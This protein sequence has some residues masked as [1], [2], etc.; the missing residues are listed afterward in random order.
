[1]NIIHQNS[2]ANP[3]EPGFS[4]VPFKPVPDI[5]T[6]STSDGDMIQLKYAHGK[7]SNASH[8]MTPIR[9]M[10]ELPEIPD[11]GTHTVTATGSVDD[12]VTLTVDSITDSSS[13]GATHPFSLAIE[14]LVP[15]MHR[16]AVIH[17]NI[18][19]YP[20]PTGNISQISGQVGPCPPI[21]IVPDENVKE[22][23]GCDCGCDRDDGDAGGISIPLPARSAHTIKSGDYGS[24]SA[25]SGITREARLQYMRWSAAFGVFRGMGGIPKGRLELMGYRYSPS[26][27][28]PAG[29]AY[30]HP[31]SSFVSMPAGG[32]AP[33]RLFR[34]RE[35][36][37]YTNYVCDA[38]GQA[39]F[40]VGSTSSS[41]N[42]AAFVTELSRAANAEAPLAEANYLRIAKVDGS[43]TF[44]DLSTGAFAGY[45]SPQDSLLTAQS[46][47]D[48]LDIVRQE[49]GTLRQI[50][51]LWDGLADITTTAEGCTIA[52]YLPGQV[53][54][55]DPANG[56]YTVEGAP[57][58][59]FTISG[60]TNACTLTVTEK[61]HTLPDS[62]P[63]YTTTWTEAD[64]LWSMTRGTGDSAVT[65]SRT[66]AASIITGTYRI[67]TTV[68]K[69]GIPAS[70]T[71]ADYLS[72]PTGELLLSRTEGYGST[73][74]QTT[75]YA[76]DQ[77]GSV[78][79]STGPQHGETRTIHDEYGRAAIV[80]M[81]WAGGQNR[82]VNTSYRKDGS[83]WSNEPSRVD[84]SVVD[85]GGIPR[86]HLREQYS[87][88]V[89]DHIKRIE[90]RSEANG[91]T[92]L[93]ITETW[94]GDAANIHARGRLHMSQSADGIQTW[95]DYAPTA[96]YGALYAITEETR[97]DGQS[98]TG[99]STRSIRYITAQGNTTREERYILDSAGAWQLL[100]AAD[101]E[102]DVQNR[103]TRRTQS[104]GRT[105]VR[106]HI[107]T[108]DLLS[109]TDENGVTTSHAYDSARQ[110]IETIRS[111]T[112]VTP[113]TV[114]TWT[115]DAHGRMLQTRRDTGPMT[116]VETTA[117]DLLGR[118]ISSTDVLGR[119]TTYAY[120][121][122][123]LT[124]TVTTPSGATFAITYN[125][126][127]SIA[128]EY[129]TGQRER[130]HTWDYN[131]ARIRET[132][133][134][135]DKTTI[136][137][138]TLT[139][140]FGQLVVQTSPTTT[141]FIYDRTTYNNKGQATQKQRDTGSGTESI[142]MAPTLY[143]Y[144][145]FG[146]LTKETWKLAATPTLANSRI[147]TWAYRVEQRDDG[148]YRITTAT[149]NNGKGTTFTESAAQLISE[150][151]ALENRSEQTDAR[152]NITA[153]WTEYGEGTTR[154]QK[155][156]LPTSTITASTTVIDGFATSQTDT[157]DVTLTAERIWT[158]TGMRLTQT[159]GRGNAT[160]TLTDMAGRTLS[161]TDA[162]GN[163][164]TTAYCPCCD[165]PAVITDALG[166]TACYAYDI[167]GR[168]TAEWGTAIQ[169]AAFT[170]DE[171]DR[172]TGLTTWRAG[173]S[174]ITSDPSERTDGDTTTW[175]YHDASG[176]V[177]RKTYANGGH[178][179]TVYTP[180]GLA[181]S[182][183]DA[184]GM[185]ASYTWDT[186]KGLCTKIEY[187]DS[188]P[189]KQYTHNHIGNLYRIADAQGTRDI[190]YNIYN[191]KDTDSVTVNGS[192]HTVTEAYDAF[193]R[194]SGYVLSK[195]GSALDTVTHGYGSYGRLALASFLHGGEKKTFT[196]AYLPGT[197]LPHTLAHP[198][199]IL[200][201]HAYE[202][203][204]DLV[205][206]MN[207]TR[208]AT[209]VVLRGYTYDEPGRPITRSCSRQGNTRN[210]TF[211]YNTRSELTG[212]NLGADDYGYAYDNIGNRKT[213]QELAEETTYDANNLNQYTAISQGIEVPF[214]PEYDE[215]G[216]QT[217]LQTATGIWAVAYNADNRPVSFTGA[218]G[219]TIVEC[220]YDY[221]GRRYMKK[222]TVNGTVTLHQFYLYR[223]YLQIAALDLTRSN[224]PALWY[225]HWDPTQPVATRPLSI[226]KNGTWFTYGHDLT[227]NVTELY[228]TD[229]TIAT[230]YDYTPYGTVTATGI[231]QPIQWSSEYNDTELGLT[232]YNYRHY[233][234]ADGRWI[235]RELIGELENKGLYNSVNNNT[236]FFIDHLGL[237]KSIPSDTSPF[238]R[239]NY[240]RDFVATP[241]EIFEPFENL[242]AYMLAGCS[243]KCC[244]N[245]LE[246]RKL[247]RQQATI[248]ANNI[249]STWQM[250]SIYPT[251]RGPQGHHD[252]AFGYYCW[253][254]GV[255]FF[256]TVYQF[257]KETQIWKA[258]AGYLVWKVQTK[259]AIHVF[260][261]VCP[262]GCS[263]NSDCC[264]V[265][266]DGFVDGKFV[267]DPT[268]W[269]ENYSEAGWRAPEKRQG[270]FPDEDYHDYT[271]IPII[272]GGKI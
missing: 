188:T 121:A 142:A 110:L 229:G 15:G 152:G 170:Y 12:S 85:A 126:D 210:D 106:T 177:V 267:R 143:E 221:M 248:I 260:V 148:T 195:A 153:A 118:A 228:K 233:N 30:R 187:S 193:G 94:Q 234:P 55:A 263:V 134:L 255:A 227:K 97:I 104:N 27:L 213:A 36:G 133:T 214:I 7:P 174:D 268:E 79:N 224:A 53:T 140:G 57:F 39:A 184:R 131:N 128:H 159:D 172:L 8:V 230:A 54:G 59:T 26:L 91:L 11:G 272:T 243:L 162:A 14:N 72:H 105:T 216:N 24:S 100:S 132:V 197:H 87:Y 158:A 151:A 122:N 32:I 73:A 141:G 96:L 71:A 82:I 115:R 232:Y 61:D 171:A 147:T 9:R 125:T 157:A 17:R 250:V 204:R 164:T 178:E 146:N 261:T 107:C 211:T 103:W 192:K 84:T 62:M 208:G 244:N 194:S 241:K 74:A 190:T 238:S 271:R 45:I 13:S 16:L 43:A 93:E 37:A 70:V 20:D 253:D 66:R 3:G 10:F 22:D 196:Y 92:R 114:T 150:H 137:S 76:Y 40:G 34:V 222:I 101:Y 252:A 29:L 109:E 156:Q 189:A 269:E 81:P 231:D 75:A 256:D 42:R 4:V 89:I 46:A 78:I 86:L 169:P 67:I 149:K 123:G 191:E 215:A 33:N 69:G 247:C 1:M 49:D 88:G 259:P 119:T 64:H 108:G 130:Y 41:T 28:S 203:R 246:K 239:G 207:A 257:P 206:A 254:W 179:D 237:K 166:N 266:D 145:S 168:K 31:A 58:K 199:N 60:D 6:R 50:W 219:Q 240:H 218:D 223:N 251:L 185:T 98:V 180:I 225:L 117:Y 2:F 38:N 19:Y 139:N 129:G 200:I 65:T 77:A 175:N 47:A 68:S 201:T 135:A 111:A 245:D 155:Q 161:A 258:H 212:A 160:T 198:N 83:A 262:C 202:Q 226:R 51:N 270:R 136:L 182:K 44:Y 144:D 21:D 5:T 205:T 217:L 35:G 186:A 56:L 265:I 112:P 23:C 113:E 209:N 99:Q 235:S 18:D 165:N 95:Y 90:T 264:T 116:T 138:Q 154:L 163:T 249:R 63:P 236:T 124:T 25:G 220:G 48:Y 242:E 181:A 120:S 167:R 183:T 127:G 52:L 80:A 176:L 102:Y 173:E